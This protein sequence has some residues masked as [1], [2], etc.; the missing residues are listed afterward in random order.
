MC[1]LAQSPDDL[2]GDAACVARAVGATGAVAFDLTAACSG[3]WQ[4]HPRQ[5]PRV[6]VRAAERGR[7]VAGFLFG[8]NT[9][10]QF[11]HNGA[12]K[13]AI[14]IGADALSRWVDW[15]DRNT[16]VLFG[17]GAGAVVMQAAADDEKSGVLGCV[18][19][20]PAAIA[21][22]VFPHAPFR[23]RGRSAHGHARSPPSGCRTRRSQV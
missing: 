23:T 6:S 22:R 1:S 15:T 5:L 20:Q 21:A 14:V 2:F 8:I 7:C 12:Y 9:A 16:C 19:E 4:H 3:V 18:R 11:L 17:D 13:T 10:S